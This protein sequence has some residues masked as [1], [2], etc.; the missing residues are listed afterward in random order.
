MNRSE[1]TLLTFL[2]G[3][4]AG[5]TAGFLFAPDKGKKTRKKISNKAHELKEDLKENVDSEK[6]RNLANTA[7][8]EVEKYGQKLTESIKN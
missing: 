1:K 4:A 8:S 3:A 2:V 5:L 7:M 6:L